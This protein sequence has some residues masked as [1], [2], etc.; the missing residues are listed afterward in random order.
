MQLLIGDDGKAT[1]Y[2]DTY[3]ITIHC[4]SEEEQAAVI[5]KLKSMDWIP[6]SERL[7][8]EGKEVFVTCGHGRFA[9]TAEGKFAHR[10]GGWV[11]A[12]DNEPLGDVIAWMPE[13][14][15]YKGG[16]AE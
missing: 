10:F 12:W 15:P 2:D 14:E 7:P 11:S 1:L 4:E 13:P 5:T 3:D 9:F 6:V 8:E 16:D